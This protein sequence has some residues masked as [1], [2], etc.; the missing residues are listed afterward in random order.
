MQKQQIK[1]FENN[2]TA[3]LVFKLKNT[4]KMNFQIKIVKINTLTYF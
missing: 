4:H 2:K 1:I 3:F